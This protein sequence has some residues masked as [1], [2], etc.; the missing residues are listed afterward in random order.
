MVSGIWLETLCAFQGRMRDV[1]ENIKTIHSYLIPSCIHRKQFPLWAKS[2]LWIRALVWK[3]RSLLLRKGDSGNPGVPRGY[4]IHLKATKG[5]TV[6]VY[7]GN[8]ARKQEC[9]PEAQ[10][11]SGLKLWRTKKTNINISARTV[12][13]N[14]GHRN[15]KLIVTWLVT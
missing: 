3:I 8:Q 15:V 7:V 4:T 2:N 13:T 5:C 14:S 10:L 6:H 11:L 12:K 9:W 1:N